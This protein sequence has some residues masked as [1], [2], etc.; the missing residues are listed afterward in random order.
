MAAASVSLESIL[1]ELKEKTAN[2]NANAYNG[3]LAVQVTLT[4]IN[5]VFYVEVKDGKLSIEPFDYRDRQA[6][7]MISSAN[8]VKMIN[9]KLN[10][11]TAFLT[12]KLKIDGDIEKAKEMSGLFKS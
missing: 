7:L 3:F 9:G 4:D 6:N 5:K 8:F 10:S 2:Y 1:Q 11:V 12:G